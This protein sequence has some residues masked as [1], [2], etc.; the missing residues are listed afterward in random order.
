MHGRG[1]KS[2]QGFGGKTR[3]KDTTCS[4]CQLYVHVMSST[5]RD[6]RVIRYTLSN[7]RGKCFLKTIRFNNQHLCNQNRM[8][9]TNSN[10][11]RQSEIVIS[12]DLSHKST[13]KKLK[14]V[15]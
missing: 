9:A 5:A 10:V 2:V 14:Y 11:P 15:F 4:S 6:I 7:S 8:S 12:L 1:E 13:I 3:R